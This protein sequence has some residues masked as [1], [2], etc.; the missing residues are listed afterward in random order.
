MKR[1][2]RRRK[3]LA[4]I[5]AAALVPGTS[6]RAF[7]EGI[8]M[9]S[10][11]TAIGY[12][13]VVQLFGTGATYDTD[14]T[15]K[16]TPNG[17]IYT[18]NP[19]APDSHTTAT[20]QDNFVSDFAGF[21]QGSTLC[22]RSDTALRV[23]FRKDVLPDPTRTEII[24]EL[25]YPTTNGSAANL[26]PFSLQI[27][28]ADVSQPIPVY[29]IAGGGHSWVPNANT[30]TGFQNV[31][32]AYF[33]SM[34]WFTRWRWNPTPRTVMRTGSQLLPAKLNLV[35]NFSKSLATTYKCIPCGTV[36]FGGISGWN[37]IIAAYSSAF[38]QAAKGSNVN[39]VGVNETCTMTAYIGAVGARPELGFLP[40]WDA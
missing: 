15:V 17:A 29:T 8:R 4:G 3:V 33:P 5:G 20:V 34:G 13:A 7:G 28:K 37:G 26:G 1:K 24:L 2:I 18:Y 22:V 30:F 36:G 23:Y 38:S 21:T 9:P 39:P 27:L 32:T 10:S 14:G 19:D 31:T 25:G 12:S 16:G 40:E 11:S 6:A 35:P